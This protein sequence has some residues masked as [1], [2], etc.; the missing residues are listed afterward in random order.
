MSFTQALSGLNAQQEKLGVVGNN[1]ANS[2]TVGFKNSNVQFADVFANS[3]VGLGVRTS[4]VLQDFSQGNIE[5]T[6][7][8]LD[9]AI[10]GEGFFRFQQTNGEIAYS[11]NG[12]LTMTA[13]G[14]LINAQ[15]AQ[16]MGYP[17][18]ADGNVQE[19]G[20]V[21]PLQIPPGDLQANATSELS[22]SLNLNSGQ[23]VIDA[24]FNPNNANTYNYSTNATVFDS[25]GNAR[26][27]TLYFTK[28]APNEWD[29]NGRL[30][31][32]PAGADTYD[33]DLGSLSFTQNG[34][35]AQ[36]N[37]NNAVFANGEFG[38]GNPLAEL[39]ID[40][41][42]E[43]TTQFASDSTVNDTIQDGYSSGALVGI[44]IEED[45]TV[46]RNYSNEQSRAS[47]Q[48]TLVTFR[49]P[50][51]LRPDGDNLW[52]ATASSGQELL[53]APGAGLRGLIQPNAIETSNVDMARELVD[54]IV[55]QRAYQANSQTISTQDELLQT[56]I[57]L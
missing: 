29:V 13:D 42:F 28:T 31:G 46:M 56:I 37:A 44:T 48:V 35:L 53:G 7:R 50:E 15:G 10:A 5:S 38:A 22:L 11:R 19:G 14:R 8:N 21:I 9:L 18:D 47:G 43:G 17:A 36:D 24:A 26:N 39:D 40:L 12:Q 33:I 49:N 54:M 27:L 25:Q 52:A 6:T 51:G 4:A 41:S 20:N 57:N 30:S 3:R 1:I 55:A 45:G 2:Q 23:P 34:T 32:G 16:I